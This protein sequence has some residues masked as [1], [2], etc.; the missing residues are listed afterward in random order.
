M[1]QL[2]ITL[3]PLDCLVR[4][5]IHF[6]NNSGKHLSDVILIGCFLQL[7]K[8]V[9]LVK[10]EA[11]NDGIDIDDDSEVSGAELANGIMVDQMSARKSK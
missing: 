11:L 1:H 4:I 2:Q 6:T 10:F 8:N 5:R 9:I 7:R 3:C